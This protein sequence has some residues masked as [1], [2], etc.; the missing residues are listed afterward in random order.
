M[1]EITILG[2]KYLNLVFL[3]TFNTE[4]EYNIIF[5]FTVFEISSG[6]TQNSSTELT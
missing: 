3:I 1:D 4:Y 6:C 5:Q 2:N